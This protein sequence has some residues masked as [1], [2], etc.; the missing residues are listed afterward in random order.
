[1][2]K[3]KQSNRP[4][5]SKPNPFYGRRKYHAINNFN[6]TSRT[7]KQYYQKTPDILSNIEIDLI[8]DEARKH[9]LRD[10]TL[11]FFALNTGL[12]NAEVIGLNVEDVYPYDIVIDTLELPARIA[13][14]KKPRS[15]PLCLDIKSA[16]E[17]YIFEEIKSGRITSFD[18]ALFRSK[19]SNKRLGTKDFHQILE[20]HSINSIHRPCNP[21]KLRHTFATKLIG[22]ANIK[23]VQEILGHAGLQSTQV[24]LHPSSSEKLDAVNKLNFGHNRKE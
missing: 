10:Y 5:K 17:L 9:G 4:Q 3:R 6:G 2:K 16:L 13:K 20:R 15:I 12:R 7:R 1:M 23:I 8:L 24:Y 22:Q 14:G 21:H 19:W 11:I 18:S